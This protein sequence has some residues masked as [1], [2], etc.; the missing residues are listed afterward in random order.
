M[1]LAIIS[2]LGLMWFMVLYSC[3]RVASKADCIMEQLFECET[4]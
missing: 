4:E 2:L 1:V 3:I